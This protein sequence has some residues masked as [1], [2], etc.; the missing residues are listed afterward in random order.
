MKC[1]KYLPRNNQELKKVIAQKIRIFKIHGAR[2]HTLSDIDVSR[3]QDFTDVFNIDALH[4]KEA[5][6]L[7]HEPYDEL[8]KEPLPNTF[9]KGIESW[10]TG[11]MKNGTRLFYGQSKMN[12]NIS[13][14]DLSSLLVGTGMF[15]GCS[16]FNISLNDTKV[17]RLE[18]GTEMFYGCSIYNHP[19][20]KWL[21]S[22]L[23][24]ATRMFGNCKELDQDFSS[25]DIS[26]LKNTVGMF[27]YCYNLKDGISS[28]DLE[29][30]KHIDIEGTLA[31]CYN[32][33]NV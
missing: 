2:N 18:D 23:V 15:Y 6:N 30:Q 12:R 21:T 27:E 8:Y 26:S 9:F 17:M 14:W 31:Y 25:W 22:R 4:V 7:H 1:Y 28:W 5:M 20:N 29:N 24:R 11:S 3:V 19:F 13:T 16:S 10:Y 33:V 32:N